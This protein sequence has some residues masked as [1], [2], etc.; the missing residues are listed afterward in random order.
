MSDA[1]ANHCFA[2]GPTN[3]IGLKITF[4]LEGEFCLASFTPGPDH[5]GY[6]QVVHGGLL[7]TALD[8]VMANWLYLRGTQA[9]TGKANIR[10]RREAEV[11]DTLQLKGW[12]TEQRSRLYKMQATARSERYDEIVCEADAVFMRPR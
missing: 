6:N 4:A 7:F 5:V 10:Y 2:C 1:G 11:G 3:P 9:F 8:D 12:C